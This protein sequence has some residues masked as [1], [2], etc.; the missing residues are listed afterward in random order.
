MIRALKG[1]LI[2]SCQAAAG[3]PLDSPAFLAALSQAVVLGGAAGIR[4]ERPDHIAAIRQALPVPL[5]GL[6]KRRYPDSE[7]HITPTL[8]DALA[9]AEAGADI[10]ALDAT[11]RPRPGGA[12]LAQTVRELRARCGCFLMADVSTEAEGLAAAELGFDCVSTTLSG[13]TAATA[14]KAMAGGPD[15]DLVHS[16]ADRLQGRVPVIAEGRISTPAQAAE[17][18]HR[19]A[20]AVVVGTAITRPTVITRR[21]VDALPARPA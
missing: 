13:Y 6:Y 20:F 9:V 14:S 1:Q 2:V 12:S 8:A 5:I 19:G 4:A 16:L 21:F 18:L 10:I 3:E 15:L 7:L 17:A 11:E